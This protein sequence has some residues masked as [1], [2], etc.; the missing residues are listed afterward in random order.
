MLMAGEYCGL[1]CR[2]V[3]LTDKYFTQLPAIIYIPEL[4][5]R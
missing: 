2:K 3:K 5:Q 1:H 4:Y